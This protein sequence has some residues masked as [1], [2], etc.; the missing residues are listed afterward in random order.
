V[1]DKN[2]LAEIHNTDSIKFVMKNGEFFESDT[3]NQL[4][5]AQKPLEK[6]YWWDTAP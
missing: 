5:P 1:L 2:P 6:Q 4:W 3:L